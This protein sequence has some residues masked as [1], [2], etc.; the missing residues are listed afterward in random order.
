MKSLIFILVITFSLVNTSNAIN[1][2]VNTNPLNEITIPDTLCSE[3]VSKTVQGTITSLS[4]VMSSFDSCTLSA[5]VSYQ[6]ASTTISITADD[7]YKAG[8]GIAQA[9]KGFMAEVNKK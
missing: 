2:E 7:C 6:G 1:S 3:I 5:E 4:V 9:V 8:A